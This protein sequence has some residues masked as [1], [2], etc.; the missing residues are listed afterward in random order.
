MLKRGGCYP[1]EEKVNKNVVYCK[2]IL[3]RK[4]QQI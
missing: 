4:L 2:R 1:D 3:I